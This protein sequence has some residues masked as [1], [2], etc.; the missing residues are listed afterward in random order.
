[1]FLVTV[2][3]GTRMVLPSTL[4]RAVNDYHPG[5]FERRLGANP[6]Q[7][8]QF[9]T[10]FLENE[11]CSHWARQHPHLRNKSVGDLICTVPLTVH[12]DAGPCTKAKSCNCISWSGLLSQ[13]EEKQCK[14]LAY[15][16]LKNDNS[17]DGPSWRRLLEDM[18]ELASGMVGGE[19]VAKRGR[20]IY[21]FVLLVCKSDEEVKANEFGLPHFNSPSG[22]C[23]DC[24]ADDDTRPWTDL[25][26]HASW[27]PTENMPFN[28]WFDRLRTPQHP[29]VNSHYNC[30]PWLF[31]LTSCTWQTAME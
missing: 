10:A 27:R 21:K 29:L 31:M 24:A 25:S 14:F 22:P 20:R 17:G 9:W 1:M 13:G 15:S 26:E 6:Q 8:R 30:V 2:W 18:D 7:L 12:S 11:L 28:V 23:G 3:L 16:Y 19:Y 4:I 5:E